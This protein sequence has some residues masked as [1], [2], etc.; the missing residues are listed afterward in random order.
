MTQLDLKSL[1]RHFFWVQRPK[2]VIHELLKN[3][4][5]VEDVT[6]IN[7]DVPSVLINGLVKMYLPN[8]IRMNEMETNEYAV[9]IDE[10]DGFGDAD[11]SLF[12]R[13]DHA[14]DKIEELLLEISSRPPVYEVGIDRGETGTET[15]ARFNTI[16]DADTFMYGY[17]MAEPNAKLF[18]DTITFDYISSLNK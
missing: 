1:D 18:V 5:K 9:L 16:V 3:F 17:Q 8:S 13:L 6:Y 14:I 10:Q 7:D 12:D 15:L 2:A 11:I 4:D